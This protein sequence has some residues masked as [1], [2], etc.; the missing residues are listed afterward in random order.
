MNKEFSYPPKVL[1]EVLVRILLLLHVPC[2]SRRLAINIY[3]LS[4]MLSP[5]YHHRSASRV[6]QGKNLATKI[7]NVWVFP[8]LACFCKQMLFFYFLTPN[9]VTIYFFI[10]FRFINFIRHE[11]NS[12]RQSKI[13]FKK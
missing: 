4:I 8:T 1:L 12:F 9:F 13:L 3:Y 10:A 5:Q 6:H 11:D 2:P 7:F